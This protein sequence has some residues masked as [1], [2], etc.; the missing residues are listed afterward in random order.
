MSSEKP[1]RFIINGYEAILFNG[2]V[3]ISLPNED[4]ASKILIKMSNGILDKKLKSLRINLPNKIIFV[5][6]HDRDN[7]L[8]RAEEADNKKLMN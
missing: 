2:Q 6:A 4:I 8:I 1:H 7:I 5:S 3:E